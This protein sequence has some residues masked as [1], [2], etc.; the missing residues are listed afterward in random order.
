MGTLQ[1][2]ILGMLNRES[3]TG[4]DLTREF[5]TSL[6]DFWT[7]KH[8]QVYPEL[9]SLLEKGFVEY[10]TEI[11]GTALEKKVY[12]ITQQGR[13]AFQDWEE[14][15][16]PIKPIPKDEFRLQ[17]FFSDAMEPETRLKQLEYHLQQ[18]R[19]RLEQIRKKQEKFETIPPK[20][21]NQFCD[22]LVMQGAIH[23]EE[24]YCRWLE[25]CIKLCQQ[26]KIL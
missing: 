1:Y 26:R 19:Q 7:A 2:A 10:E 3:M 22:Y 14:K 15:A 18:H 20:E 17:L 8:S 25:E 13:D 9:K 24:S 6:F 11:S 16:Y 5:Q 21:E 23:R 12:T 4:Y